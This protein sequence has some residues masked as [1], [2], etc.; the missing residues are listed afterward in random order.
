MR[1]W[2]TVRS[3]GEILS[4]VNDLLTGEVDGL[5]GY[6]RMNEAG[7]ESLTDFAGG[8]NTGTISNCPWVNGA[9]FD[10]NSISGND[11]SQKFS[12]KSISQSLQSKCNNKL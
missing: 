4:T 3:Q 2:D 6:W 5:V 9:S 10:V 11:I 1:L 8:N 7:G 12:A